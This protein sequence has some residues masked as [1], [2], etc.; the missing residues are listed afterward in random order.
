MIDEQPFALH[1]TWTCYGAWL[2]GDPRGHVS[3]TRFT[4]GGY[5]RKANIVGTPYRRGDNFTRQQAHAAQL[6]PSA[7][8]TAELALVAAEALCAAAQARA[9][10]FCAEH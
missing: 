6:A 3:N 7:S 5:L 10:E 2:P 4:D 1:I 9:G 8:L